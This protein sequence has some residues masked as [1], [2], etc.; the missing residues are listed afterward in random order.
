MIEPRSAGE[1]E[2]VEG[3]HRNEEVRRR[4]A[5]DVLPRQVGTWQ[6]D[7]GAS[8][9]A[10]LD[11]RPSRSALTPRASTEGW[12]HGQDQG[13][14][15]GT[16]Q[17][18]SAMSR[19]SPT[20]VNL[21]ALQRMG[22]VAG[23]LTAGDVAAQQQSQN[24]LMS[25]LG[26]QIE[27]QQ[28]AARGMGISGGGAE[29]A[30]LVSAAGSAGQAG[31]QDAA[32]ILGAATMRDLEAQQ[33]MAEMADLYGSQAYREARQIAGAEDERN[34]FNTDYMQ[35]MRARDLDR[36]VAEAVGAGRARSLRDEMALNAL[37]TTQA[38]RD[39][40]SAA[41]AGRQRVLDNKNQSEA[42]A[43]GAVLQVIAKLLGL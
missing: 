38:D 27:S 14:R 10:A 15:A 20:S 1:D 41:A 40:V 7:R 36:L 37:Q 8:I 30:S 24:T 26:R 33:Q 4:V 21:A 3:M 2:L 28:Q 19:V 18:E 25:Q 34:I 23:S 42:A 13:S 5:R 22:N 29:L 32:G 35:N 6:K 9:R 16:M 43:M 31:A 17:G 12:Y 39:A 11:K